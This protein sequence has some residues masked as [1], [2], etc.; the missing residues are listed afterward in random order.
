MFLRYGVFQ[1]G[2]LSSS[3]PHCLP[4]DIKILPEALKDRGYATHAV[5]K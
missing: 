3:A 4:T 5:G 1:T 2:A